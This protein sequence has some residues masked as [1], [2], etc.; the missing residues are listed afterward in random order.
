MS[1]IEAQSAGMV[2]PG[3][4]RAFLGFFLIGMLMGIPGTALVVWGY[5]L[6]PPYVGIG[7]HFL[8]F[9]GGVL[10]ALWASRQILD[11]MGVH[12]ALKAGAVVAA[13]GIVMVGMGAPPVAE[14]WRDLALGFVGVAQGMVMGATFQLLRR[15]YEQDPAATV[16]LAGGLMGLGTFMTALLGALAYAGL[17]FEGVF[18][19]V[20]LAP[21][22]MAVWMFRKGNPVR[23][24]GLDLG[25]QAVWRETRSPVHVLFAGLL[26]FETAAEVSVLEWVPLHLVLR[27]G[28]SPGQALGILSYYCMVLLAGR[29]VAQTLMRHVAHRRLLLASAAMSWVGIL[30]F[31]STDNR[32]GALLGLSLAGFGFAFVYP[33]LVERIG[34]RFV[35]YQSS[36]FHGIF[37]L[38][39][40]GGFLAPA[41]IAFGAAWG[42]ETSAMTV[43][44]WCSLVVFVILALIWVESKISGS[45]VVRS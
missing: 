6:N 37:G 22:G 11:W 39:M 21:F 40:L 1:L 15:L 43:P 7:V 27:S 36:L 38:G 3:S 32:F 12:G 29:I 2:K 16:N 41:A 4:R 44:L 18:L 25:F 5:H 20:S 24:E 13:I 17:D 35:E 31:G 14:V 10:A 19:L 8:S 26:F 30:M 34:N 23:E 42:S 9:A 33:L 28:M 45:R